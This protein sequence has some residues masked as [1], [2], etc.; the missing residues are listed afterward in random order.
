MAL[1]PVV[2]LLHTRAAARS[3]PG[4]RTDGARLALVVEG[5]GMR[6]V[7]SSA[8]TQALEEAG[9]TACFALVVGCS[10]GALNAAA[11]L[12]GVAAGCTTE[13]AGAFASPR[14]KR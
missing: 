11:L 1:H 5:G 10:A 2:D 4:A 9:L 12:S 3:A 6:G 7:V 13:Y 14:L 8:M